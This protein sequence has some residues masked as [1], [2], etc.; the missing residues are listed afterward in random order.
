MLIVEGHQIHL[1]KNPDQFTDE[2][3]FEFCNLN[4]ELRIERDA[5]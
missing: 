5:Q 3:L 2:E 4:K 1:H